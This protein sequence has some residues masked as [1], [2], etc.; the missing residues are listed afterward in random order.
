MNYSQ[1]SKILTKTSNYFDFTKE[2]FNPKDDLISTMA[3][4][5]FFKFTNQF[6]ETIN[7][8]DHENNMK[9]EKNQK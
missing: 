5:N 1:S 3:E 4:T 8:Q 7:L 6:D 2:K 9:I